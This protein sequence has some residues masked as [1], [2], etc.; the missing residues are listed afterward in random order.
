MTIARASEYVLAAEL[1]ATLPSPGTYLRCPGKVGTAILLSK[2][3]RI[4]GDTK[5]MVRLIGMRV[6]AK[7]IPATAEPLPWPSRSV[8]RPSRA[9]EPPAPT[10][11][12]IATRAAK[13]KHE[14]DRVRKHRIDA[15]E[16]VAFRRQNRTAHE[17]TWRDPADVDVRRRSPKIITGM[18]AHD[19]LDALQQSGT[20][21]RAQIGAAKR[22]R[23][24]W[25]IGCQMTGG[26]VDWEKAP[27][28]QGAVPV[29]IS[30]RVMQ[31]LEP[32][33]RAKE[34]LGR[35]FEIVDCICLQEQAIK[36]YAVRWRINPSS[37]SGRLYSAVEALRDHYQ[38]LDGPT[39]EK[40]RAS[41]GAQLGLPDAARW[42]AD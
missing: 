38:K 35:L 37:A 13:A 17:A 12:A 29:G 23:R 36:D 19:G 8:G 30:E 42:A 5:P 28:S 26:S 16:P 22:L 24:D 7:D 25:E 11:R 20:L 39:E 3:R 6:R 21:T 31:F 18:R 33:T 14:R 9:A 34:A 32:F 10:E 1:F 2:V 4:G 41:I 27:T 15:T 40:S